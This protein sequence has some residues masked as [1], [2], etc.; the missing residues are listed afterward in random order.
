VNL[1]EHA[2]VRRFR[3]SNHLSHTDS[4]QPLYAASFR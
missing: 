2:T 4:A 1:A 3:E